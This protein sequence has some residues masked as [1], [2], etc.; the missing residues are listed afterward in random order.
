[1][2]KQRGGHL[3][4]AYCP[5]AGSSPILGQ[6]STVRL[7][8]LKKGTPGTDI[9]PSP[10]QPLGGYRTL[11]WLQ[12]YVFLDMEDDVMRCVSNGNAGKCAV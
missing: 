9:W 3:S 2:D 10:T 5:W 6:R 1:M 4:T 7:S 11:G 12:K 8:M